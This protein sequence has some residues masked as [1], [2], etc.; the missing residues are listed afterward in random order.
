[1]VTEVMSNVATSTLFLPVL[2]QLV[3][4][5]AFPLTTPHI[6]HSIQDPW[7]HLVVPNLLFVYEL[8]TSPEIRTPH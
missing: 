6:D 3:R 8:Y 5:T 4:E 1:M 2:A 7:T